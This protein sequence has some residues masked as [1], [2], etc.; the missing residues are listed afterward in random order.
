MILTKQ[1]LKEFLFHRALMWCGHRD[2]IPVTS[3]L[4]EG[5]L[6]QTMLCNP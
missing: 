3:R 5:R 1:L 4:L 6:A 2:K